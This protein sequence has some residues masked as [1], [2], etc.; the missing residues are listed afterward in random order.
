M[1]LS[2]SCAVCQRQRS[3]GACRAGEVP[4]VHTGSKS[5]TRKNQSRVG[6]SGTACDCALVRRVAAG[7]IAGRS[8]DKG[9]R[10]VK[11]DLGMSRRSS[12]AG[13][14]TKQECWPRESKRPREIF[15]GLPASLQRKETQPCAQTVQ[16]DCGP[17][18]R[19]FLGNDFAH[20]LTSRDGP[21]RVPASVS[22]R[23]ELVILLQ[24]ADNS[25]GLKLRALPE[26]Y[27]VAHLQSVH[28]RHLAVQNFSVA[29][30]WPHAAAF[31]LKAKSDATFEQL[32][33]ELSECL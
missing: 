11:R 15:S 13:Q 14:E 18:L 8:E 25:V 17:A 28:V 16:P 4:V 20:D 33:G 26:Q 2:H 31:G 24:L 1:R 3:R 10:K 19:T 6:I 30:E 7:R 29:N 32:I 23:D 22:A 12:Q 27:D 21:V 5:R 9:R